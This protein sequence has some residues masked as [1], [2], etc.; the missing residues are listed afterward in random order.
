VSITC[1]AK[2]RCINKKLNKGSLRPGAYS[3]E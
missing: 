2:R 1:I 3:I